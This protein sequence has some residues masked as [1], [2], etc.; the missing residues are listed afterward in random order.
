M[1]SAFTRLV[2]VPVA[3]FLLLGAASPQLRVRVQADKLS[4]QADGAPLYGVLW[5][6]SAQT[7]IRLDLKGGMGSA[8]VLVTEDFKDVP[9]ERGMTRLLQKYLRPSSYTLVIDKRTGAVQAVQVLAG[10]SVGPRSSGNRPENAA[11]MGTSPPKSGGEASTGSH[12]PVSQAIEVA[13]SASDL[14]SQLKAIRYLSSFQDP[15]VLAVLHPA[16][17]SEVSEV[18]KAALET[19]R[20]TT[21]DDAGALADVR[22]LTVNDPDP[23]V[24]QAAFE[25]LVRY[26]DES[27]EGR[28][29][30]ENLATEPGGA[31]AARARKTLDRLDREAKARARP[32][33]QANPQLMPK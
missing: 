32:D 26:D 14:E 2:L 13:R 7:G 8:D 4:V 6:I 5:A 9:L 28:A 18:R 24:R 10:A 20:W 30:L 29:L 22:S 15:R 21:V 25:V 16:L 19:L 3:G 11:A 27:P 31:F 17:G 23:A 33:T 12:D 1:N